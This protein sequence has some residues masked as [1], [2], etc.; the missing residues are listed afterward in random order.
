MKTPPVL[1]TME[2]LLLLLIVALAALARFGYVALATDYGNAAP[3]LEVQGPGPKSSLI[4]NLREHRW[5]G[6]Q[7]PLSDGEEATA[8]IAPGYSYLVA[9]VQS[10][11][12]PADTIIRWAQAGLGVLTVVC[13]FF[14]VRRAFFNSIA[15]LGAGLLAALHPFWIINAAE[16]SDGTLTTFLLAA[17]LA[18]GTRGSQSG[19]A[20]TSLLFGL[21]LAALAMVRA[22]LLPFA[23]IGLLWFLY[24]CWNVRQG[25]FHAILAFLGFAN[26]LAPWAVRNW[27][28]FEEPVPIVDSA[29]LHLWIGNNPEATGG[30]MDEAMLRETL[31]P[32]R[33]NEL[34]AETNQARR[35]ASLGH[36]VLAE[37]ERDL[38]A[39]VARRWA[40]GMRFVLGDQWFTHQRM[41]RDVNGQTDVIVAPA[42]AWLAVNVEAILQGFLL[43]LV[44]LGLLGWRF[45]FA[46]KGQVRL[47]TFAILWLPLPYLLTHAEELSGPRLPWD[48]CLICFAAY[49]LASLA[50]GTGKSSEVD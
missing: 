47:A 46:W 6:A 32:E 3:A 45:S 41:S 40:A 27:R 49:A 44:V 22:A 11:D 8:H 2:G 36:D 1:A 29:Y 12:W 31:A 26:G 10:F 9:Q 23:A 17:A 38:G 19:D 42:P 28:E 7:A 18:L 15:A 20:V 34:L 21:C 48:A 39:T 14:F 35:Y 24:Q 25:W 13:L 5:F 43:V 16:L 33:L 50:P 37:I 30:P 4:D